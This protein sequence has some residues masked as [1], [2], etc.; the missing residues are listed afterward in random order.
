MIYDNM[1]MANF[2]TL[3]YPPTLSWAKMLTLSMFSKVP[4]GKLKKVMNFV[5]I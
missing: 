1:T 3:F 5:L 4:R 2:F